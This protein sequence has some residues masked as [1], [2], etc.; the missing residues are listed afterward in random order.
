MVFQA[1]S[2]VTYVTD[3]LHEAFN[4]FLSYLSHFHNEV[5]LI[6]HFNL[7]LRVPFRRHGICSEYEVFQHMIGGPENLGEEN[8][9][10]GT[11]VPPLQIIITFTIRERR[12]LNTNKKINP[13]AV[14][15]DLTLI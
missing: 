5:L 15:G 11:A 3:I 14:T 2:Y 1:C 4:L 8:A 9:T 7:A 12:S 10:E 6:L 13:K